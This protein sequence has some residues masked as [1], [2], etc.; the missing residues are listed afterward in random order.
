MVYAVS[1]KSMGKVT[2]SASANSVT[3][4]W[5]KVSSAMGYRIYMKNSSGYKLLTSVTTAGCNLTSLSSQTKYVFRVAAYVK[6][7]SG[8]YEGKASADTVIYTKPAKVSSLRVSTRTVSTL[9]LRWNTVSRADGYY[10]YRYSSTNSTWVKCGSST[11][12]I[13]RISGLSAGTVY[14][15]RVRAYKK[16]GETTAYGEY[17]DAFSCCTTP[18]KMSFKSVSRNGSK[19]TVKWNKVKASGYELY[20]KTGSGSYTKKA[21]LTADKTGAVISGIKKGVSYYFKVRA[22]VKVGTVKYYSSFSSAYR[23]AY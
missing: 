9:T 6:T 4:K 2:A 16:T 21:D 15:F 10:I 14:K 5:S 7:S 17:S 22:Y 8:V 12:A 20:V 23:Y 13:K 1:V 3:L 11:S 19:L 18:A